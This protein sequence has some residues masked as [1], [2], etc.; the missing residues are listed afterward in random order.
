M[1]ALLK[2]FMDLCLLRAAPQD[3]PASQTLLRLT[4]AANVLVSVVLTLSMRLDTAPTLLQSLLEI[5][6]L[7]GLLWLVL[8]LTDRSG[9]FLQ[10]A[11]AAMGSSALL[12]VLA[13]PVIPMAT[14]GEGDTALLGGLLMLGLVIWSVLVLGHILRHALEVPLGRGVL[15]AMMYTFASYALMGVL[16]PVA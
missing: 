4:V 3:L 1:N 15:L 8:R 7:L 14:R 2:Y 6:L 10:C 12:G 5:L 9:R 16:F 11:A 13:L